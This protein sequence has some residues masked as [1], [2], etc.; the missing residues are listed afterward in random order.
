MKS[1]CSRPSATV[2]LQLAIVSAALTVSPAIAR[3]ECWGCSALP[4]RFSQFLG[5]GYGAGHYAPII[6]TPGLQPQ[7]M[8]RWTF[9]RAHE[10]P[11][12]PAPYVPQRCFG[13]ACY[14]PATCTAPSQPVL[15]GAT[16][17]GLAPSLELARPIA[18]QSSVNA[19]SRY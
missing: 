4:S 16:A 6:K 9:H 17:A 19:P 14:D 15:V 8:P 10:R 13:E 1:R 5:W 12:Y 7:P 18:L 11:L 3:T 2:T